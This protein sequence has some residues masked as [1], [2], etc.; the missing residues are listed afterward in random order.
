MRY[1]FSWRQ[2]ALDTIFKIWLQYD[3]HHRYRL[4]APW[5]DV[6]NASW[7]DKDGALIAR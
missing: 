5:R 7:L 6:A 3:E 1:L 4:S 2:I